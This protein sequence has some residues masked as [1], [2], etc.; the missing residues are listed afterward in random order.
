MNGVTNPTFTYDAN[1]NMLCE[2]ANGTGGAC[3]QSDTRDISWTSF[4]QPSQIA[5]GAAAA[6]LYYGPDH[7]RALM[8]VPKCL[9]TIPPTDTYYMNDPAVG[10]MTEL[11]TNGNQTPIWRTYIVAGGR[12]VAEQI[13]QGSTTS[14]LYFVGDDVAPN[15][16]PVAR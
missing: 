16:Y 9:N 14:T 8:C 1:G 10:S 5:A 4:N 11:V 12:T 15:F 3:T 2:Q 6:Q 7:Q 13:V